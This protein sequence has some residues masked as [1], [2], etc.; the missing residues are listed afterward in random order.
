MSETTPTTG[1]AEIKACCVATYGSD[2]VTL[3]LG[4][5]YHPGGL[6]LTRRL[7]DRLGLRHG[8]RVLDVAAG[9]GTTVRLLAKEYGVSVDGVDLDEATVETAYGRIDAADPATIRFH[10]GD[11]ERIPL[12]DATFDAVVCECAFCMF[13]GKAAAAA[14]FTRVLRPG[15][16]VGITDVTVAASGL[17]DELRTLAGWV[18]CIADARPLTAYT[19]ILAAAGLRTVHTETH[20]H[21]ATR[22]IEQIEARLRL[23]RMTAPQRLAAAGVD[24]DTVLHYTARAGEAA[25]DGLIGYALLIAEKPRDTVLTSG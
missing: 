5:S 1:P 20:D 16:R 15:G 2:A 4:D 10:R 19:D 3:L 6:A 18:A 9:V 17:P 12:P 7:A 21:A 14:E 8:Q 24:V 11:A 13:P 22:M 23:L 25:A